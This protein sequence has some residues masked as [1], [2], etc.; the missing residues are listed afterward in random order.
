MS[1]KTQLVREQMASRTQEAWKSLKEATDHN[2]K[3]VKIKYQETK[4]KFTKMTSG[5]VHRSCS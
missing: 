4:E 1:Q 3:L 2:M 5:K